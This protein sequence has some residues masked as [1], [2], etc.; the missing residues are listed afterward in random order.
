MAFVEKFCKT[1]SDA[2]GK[3]HQEQY[4]TVVAFMEGNE[5]F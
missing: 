2:V 5:R 3:V 4:C 1:A